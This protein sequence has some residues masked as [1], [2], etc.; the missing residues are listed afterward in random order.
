M[1]VVWDA[2]KRMKANLEEKAAALTP[3]FRERYN[4]LLALH[5]F[6]LDELRSK[7]TLPLLRSVKQE[8]VT[9]SGKPLRE[10]LP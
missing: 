10:L 4:S 8:G 1:R 5:C 9:L 3:F 6:T 2:V 7:R